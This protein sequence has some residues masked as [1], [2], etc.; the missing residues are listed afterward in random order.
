MP[1]QPSK[2]AAKQRERL[3]AAATR[4]TEP[5]AQ[6]AG[7]TAI[8]SKPVRI[9]I[10]LSPEAY[11]EL[12]AWLASAAEV[13][14]VPRLSQADAIRA[15]IRAARSESAVSDEVLKVLRTAL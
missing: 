6:P 4:R 9:T 8:R 15:M 2:A 3:M 14:D 7:R 1:A 11:R 10:D 5:D 13:L 12:S